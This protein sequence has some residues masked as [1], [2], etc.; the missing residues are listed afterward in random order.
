[1]IVACALAAGAPAMA[2]SPGSERRGPF[3]SRDEWL[4]AQPL[5]TLPATSPDPLPRGRYE[6][7]LDGDW[8]SDFALVETAGR[9]TPDLDYLVDGEHRSGALTVRRGLGRGLSLGLR[10]PVLWRGGGMLDGVIDAWHRTFDLPDGGRSLFPDDRLRVEARDPQRRLLHWN[11]RQGTGLGNLEV[12]AHQVLFGLE[13]ARGWRGAAVLRLSAPTATGPFA[14]AGSAAGLQ[15]VIARPLGARTNVYAGLGATAFSRLDVEGI[16]YRRIRGQ[17]FLSFEGRL[18]HGWSV[19][20]Q[21]DA[22]TRLVTDIAAYPGDTVYLRVGSK[23]GL[24]G[25]WTLEGGITEGV[26]N[27]VA[28]TD[29]GLVAGIAR[30]F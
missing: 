21:L 20:V 19:I 28:A 25:K 14:H 13:D 6:A 22:A 30:G 11:G 16:E 4:L 26:K 27:Q 23:F 8:G 15:F 10:L 12:E 9:P 24:H 29:F 7:R 18:T 17:G 2:Q 5:L 1:M 3:P